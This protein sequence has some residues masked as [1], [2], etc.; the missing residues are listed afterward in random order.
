MFGEVINHTYDAI[1]SGLDDSSKNVQALHEVKDHIVAGIN[2]LLTSGAVDGATAQ[3]L[4][5]A[6]H[7][8]GQRI[9]E[10]GI[11]LSTLG[12]RA[13]DQQHQT[14]ALDIQGAHSLGC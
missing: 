12:Q 8:I 4:L 11:T 2:D 1:F 9:D 13:A 7:Q 10:C 5:V 14:H 3:Q 6:Q